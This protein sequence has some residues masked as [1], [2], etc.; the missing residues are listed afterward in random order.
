MLKHSTALTVPRLFSFILLTL[1]LLASNFTLLSA[2]EKTE[3]L[4]AGLVNP[5]YEEKPDWFKDSFLD[6]R[7]DIAEAEEEGK[8]VVLYFY[9]DGCPYC[10][11]LLKDNFG[12][13]DIA[14][15]TQQNFDVIALNMWGDRE[16]TD[17]AG[18]DSTEKDFAA[19]L[20]VQYTPTLIFFDEAGK[21]AL[22]VNG[23]YSPDEFTLA[24]DF[25]AGKHE[26]QGSIRDYLLKRIAAEKAAAENAEKPALNALASGLKQ[27]LQLAQTL[28]DNKRPLL[29]IFEQ[30]DCTHCDELHNDV[31]KRQEIAYSLSNLDVAQVNI[32]AED[33][34][35]T[36]KGETLSMTAWAKQ[37]GIKYTPSLVFFDTAGKEVFRTEAYLK[38][39]HLHGAMDYASSQ[40][41]QHQPSFQRFLQH[42]MDVMQA[43]GFEIDLMQ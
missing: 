2:A 43:Q 27:P 10:G 17:L 18:E 38:S 16:V 7:E 1:L 28:Q 23:Y 21:V 14:A 24:L 35:Q 25:V 40:A 12:D 13:P 3:G 29:V 22:R 32:Q 15:M 6:I 37:I 26:K 36:P 5:G 9:Q 34:L 8:R 33:T 20:K 4:A 42:R 11:K 31:L 41:Y 39:F 19:A 30:P